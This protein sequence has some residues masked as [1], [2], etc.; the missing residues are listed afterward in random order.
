MDEQ[1]LNSFLS[2]KDRIER[3]IS[4]ELDEKKYAKYKVRN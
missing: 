1:T 4:D 2:E 3:A